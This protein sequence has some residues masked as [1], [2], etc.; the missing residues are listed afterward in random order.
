M[1]IRN[2]MKDTKEQVL[3]QF[4]NFV[5]KFVS[6]GSARLA[7]LGGNGVEAK[8]WQERGIP[9]TN[10]WLIE[11]SRDKSGNLI[12]THR[13]NVQNQLSTFPQTLRGLGHDSVDAFHLDLCGTLGED[14]TDNAKRVLELVFESTGRTLAVTVSDQRRSLILEQWEDYAKRARRLLGDKAESILDGIVAEQRNLPVSKK[15]L[16]AFFQA[17]DPV[18]GAKRELGLMVDFARLLKGY[19]FKCS[20]MERYVYV[21]NYAQ[22]AFRMRT[23]FF[24]FESMVSEK[25]AD[26]LVTEWLRSPLYFV[27]SSEMTTVSLTPQTVNEEKR[28]T[29]QQEEKMTTMSTQSRLAIIASAAGGDIE[30][31]YLKLVADSRKLQAFQSLLHDS[32]SEHP[33]VPIGGLPPPETTSSR[34]GKPRR[35]DSLTF[36]EQLQWILKALEI[37]SQNGGKWKS[38]EQWVQLLKQD[39]GGYNIPL[40]RCLGGAIAHS[41]GKFRKKFVE[42]VRASFPADE[43]NAYVERLH[44]F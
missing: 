26:A 21:S 15:K 41:S 5:A 19:N 16:P 34:S 6:L 9:S 29:K 44:K 40:G 7:T 33:R 23:Y 31:E 35:W 27:T 17:S 1:K 8:V 25:N 13:Y 32:N 28:T 12:A 4:L 42:R 30:E 18:K 14:L 38:K 36:A 20:Q 24:H 43:A 11:R 39:F 3:N 2:N 37:K 10:G 22:R